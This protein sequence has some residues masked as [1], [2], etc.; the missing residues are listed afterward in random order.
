ML[1]SRIDIKVHDYLKTSS[2]AL[3]QDSV[4]NIMTKPWTLNIRFDLFLLTLCNW[5]AS[6]ET[7]YIITYRW[8]QTLLKS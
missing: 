8:F 6:S 7:Y 4:D 5:K 2:T 1:I 3:D